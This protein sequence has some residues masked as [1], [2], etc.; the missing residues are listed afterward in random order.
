[1]S[2]FKNISFKFLIS[3]DNVPKLNFNRCI[4]VVFFLKNI[5][6]N[7][8]FGMTDRAL[9]VEASG[10]INALKFYH[11]MSHYVLSDKIYL[12]YCPL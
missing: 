5:Y 11:N 3:N 7:V 4:L 12:I 8:K 9:P 1:M 10:P 2:L 6:S